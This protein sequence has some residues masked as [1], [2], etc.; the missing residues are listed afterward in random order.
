MAIIKFCIPQMSWSSVSVVRAVPLSEA[1][2]LHVPALKTSGGES[3]RNCGNQR[4]S[5][6]HKNGLLVKS[7]QNILNACIST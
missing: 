2:A 5:Q 6:S 7:L 3:T 1:G 4:N